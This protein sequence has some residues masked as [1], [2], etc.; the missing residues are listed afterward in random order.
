MAN[1]TATKVQAGRGGDDMKQ[2]ATN[3]FCF[4]L[5]NTFPYICRR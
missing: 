1:H 3:H 2:D 4:S 5:A